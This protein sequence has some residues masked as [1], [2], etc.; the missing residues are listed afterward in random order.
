MFRLIN[1]DN[2]GG[3]VAGSR[4]PVRH[5]SIA[6]AGDDLQGGAVDELVDVRAG[7]GCRGGSK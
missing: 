6:A 1:W 7:V 5:Q 2:L 4:T 3:A